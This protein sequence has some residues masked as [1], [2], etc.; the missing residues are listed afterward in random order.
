VKN[1]LVRLTGLVPSEAERDMAE[2]DAW[3]VFGVDRVD[4][5]IKV[6]R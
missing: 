4:D 6:R 1:A 2:F 3:Y 5:R